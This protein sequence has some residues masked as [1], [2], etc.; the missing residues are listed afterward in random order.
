MIYWLAVMMGCAYVAAWQGEAVTWPWL[1]PISASWYAGYRFRPPEGTSDPRRARW[2]TA[3]LVAMLGVD[4]WFS[5]YLGALMHWVGFILGALL[6]VESKPYAKML[7]LSFTIFAA[8]TAGME[9]IAWIVFFGIFLVAAIGVMWVTSGGDEVGRGAWRPIGRA[10]GAVVGVAAVIFVALPRPGPMARGIGSVPQRPFFGGLAAFS[11]LAD[12]MRL[13]RYGEIKRD[14]TVLLRVE[15]PDLAGPLGE[16]LRLRGIV[17]DTFDGTQWHRQG[18]VTRQVEEWQRR[19]ARLNGRLLRQE[20]YTELAPL[21]AVVGVPTLVNFQTQSPFRT[22]AYGAYLLSYPTRIMGRYTVT[23]YVAPEGPDQVKEGGDMPN[24]AE[25][26]LFV[27][28]SRPLN[29][30]LGQLAREV[31]KDASTREGQIKALVNFF[32]DQFR[33]TTNVEATSLEDFLWNTRQGHCEYFASALCL[34][35]RSL[36][37]PA[38]VANGFLTTEYN[39][40]GNFYVVRG[41]HAHAW[42]EI[43]SP[44]SGWVVVDATPPAVRIQASTD[45]ATRS[46]WVMGWQNVEMGW[47]KYVVD[48]DFSQQETLGRGLLAAVQWLWIPAGLAW[49]GWALKRWVARHRLRRSQTFYDRMVEILARQGLTRFSHLT[50]QEFSQA[51]VH[52]PVGGAVS[53]LTRLYYETRFAGRELTSEDHREIQDR[54]KTLARSR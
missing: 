23:S 13:G 16:G 43:L 28:S 50:P 7:A 18:V 9:Q 3:G 32:H 21:D 36:G 40:M 20:I 47:R 31:T 6:F 42:A 54:L 5:G 30:R 35:A 29:E 51:L 34:M 14:P 37:I 38:R 4:L 15:L 26:Y 10:M 45:N 11:G 22:D 33:Y 46:L 49:L 19:K 24:W 8:A 12:T 48:F 2:V 17:F 25:W 39:P 53:D 1:I 44:V 41:A 27:T 52:L